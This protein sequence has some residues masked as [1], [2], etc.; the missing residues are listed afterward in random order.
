MRFAA[1][2]LVVFAAARRAGER[3]TRSFEHPLVAGH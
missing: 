2:A 3:A 1:V